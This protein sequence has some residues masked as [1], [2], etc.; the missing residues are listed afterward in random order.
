[1]PWVTGTPFPLKSKESGTEVSCAWSPKELQYE[2]QK[3]ARRQWYGFQL[4]EY[5]SRFYQSY[6]DIDSILSIERN[7]ALNA[8]A[9]PFFP[10]LDEAETYYLFGS[11]LKSPNPARRVLQVVI[12][13]RRAWI[14][15]IVVS[16]T[17]LKLSVGGE[18]VH[19]CEVKLFGKKPGVVRVVPVLEAVEHGIPLETFPAELSERASLYVPTRVS[20]TRDEQVSIEGI[21]RLREGLHYEYKETFIPKILNTVCAFANTEGGSILNRGRR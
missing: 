16:N 15:R 9:L 7:Q 6:Q 8:P 5:P 12:D 19:G 14:E 11:V 4:R 17:G 13:D 3:V 10:S 1:M 20:L 21:I 18:M 2:F